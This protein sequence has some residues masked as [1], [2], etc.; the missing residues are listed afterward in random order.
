MQINQHNK[1]NK[2]T[3]LPSPS[4][5]RALKGDLRSAS[6]RKLSAHAAPS[7]GGLSHRSRLSNAG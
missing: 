3:N 6:K 1:S 2:M 5:Q 4:Q 7:Q